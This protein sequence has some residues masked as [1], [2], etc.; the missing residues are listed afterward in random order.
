RR[1][2]HARAEGGVGGRLSPHAARQAGGAAQRGLVT[3]RR[4]R[5]NPTLLVAFA[6]GVRHGT[7]PD[8]LTAIDGLS[9]IRPRAT[10]GLLFAVGHG[11]VVTL[12]AAGAGHVIAGHVAFLGPWMLILIGAVNLWKVLRPSPAPGAAKAPVVAQPFLL[13]ML[14]AAGFETAS[15]LSALILADRANPWLL[16]A[17]FSGG[18]VIVDG[19]DGYLAATTLTMAAVGNARARTASR[20]LGLIVVVFSF[21]LGGAELAGA[22]LGAFALPLRLAL[23]A[24]VV[25][26]R[27]WVGSG[28][29]TTDYASASLANDPALTD[30]P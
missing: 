11:L 12:L 17:A 8:H 23:F 9:R 2:G 4:R 16:G 30:A 28:R 10:N 26:V 3:A 13:G 18:M 19:V 14:L 24:V 29:S 21:G 22:E 6:L 25:G 5:V 27:V 20:L 15:Q 1:G 7:D